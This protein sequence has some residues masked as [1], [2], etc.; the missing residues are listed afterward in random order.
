MSYRG[1]ISLGATL[2]VKFTTRQFSTGAPFALSGGAVA[3]YVDNSTTEITAGITLSANFDGRTG[4]NNVR[5]VASS[6]NGFAGGTNVDLVLTAGTVDGV[7]VAGEA[8]AS[9]SIANRGGM[10]DEVL[11]GATHNIASSAGRRLRQL[12]TATTAFSGTISSPTATTVVLDV[13]A[14]GT[15]DFY[16]PG[17][18]VIDGVAGIQFRRI[19]SY[20]GATRTVTVATA[21]ATTPTG[22]DAAYIIPWA[23]VRVSEID[24]DVITAAAIANGAIDAAT[25]AAGAIDAA[26]IAAGAI[27]A[28]EAPALANLDVAVSTRALP[29]DAMALTTAERG[30]VADKILGRSLATGAD[31]GRTVQDALRSLRNRQ[32]IAAG[33][34][35]VY[36]ENDTTAA[37]TAA[38]TTAAGNPLSEIDPA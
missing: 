16:K 3:A 30:S 4:L 12:E 38:I 23:T 18:L 1:D 13:A 27:T 19:T 26:A 35:T 11:T 32:A 28:S 22:G 2:D 7:S 6:G 10:W 21:F 31:G 33:T 34:L 9:F 36:Q 20:V 37:W 14:S 15:D 29:G 24:N 8:V 25:F 5:V 17:L